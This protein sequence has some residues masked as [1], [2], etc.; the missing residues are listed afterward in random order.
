M[1]AIEQSIEQWQ[2]WT[3]QMLTA[4]REQTERVA[5]EVE[6]SARANSRKSPRKPHAA[7]PARSERV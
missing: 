7:L 3:E 6:L 5:G 1:R 4:A 2:R